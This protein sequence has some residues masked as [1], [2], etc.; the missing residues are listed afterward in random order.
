MEMAVINS[1]GP[2]IRSWD[3]PQLSDHQE[4]DSVSKNHTSN[5]P[6]QKITDEE[7]RYWMSQLNNNKSKVARK[8]GVS[9]R[10]I[11][12]RTKSMPL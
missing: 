6:A 11:L 1:T 2:V 9:Y 12:R 10:T 8:L 4:A 5:P 7:V 3:F